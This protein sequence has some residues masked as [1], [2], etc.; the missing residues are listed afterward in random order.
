MNC[1]AVSAN[2]ADGIKGGGKGN[3]LPQQ[4]APSAERLTNVLVRH[5]G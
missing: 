4:A 3:A 5:R 2:E 1:G